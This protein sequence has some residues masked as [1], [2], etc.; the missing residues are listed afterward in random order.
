M[1]T[2]ARMESTEKKNMIQIF[3]STADLL[4]EAGK[5][6]WF[7]TRDGLVTAKGKGEMQ[8]Y[9]IKRRRRQC[10]PVDENDGLWKTSLN[11][12]AVE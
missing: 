11:M 9:W 6:H 2:A 4:V 10:D 5:E 3:Q 7:V 8:T 1:N 12:E